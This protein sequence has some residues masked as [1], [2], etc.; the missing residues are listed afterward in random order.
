MVLVEN[1]HG[2]YALI[3]FKAHSVPYFCHLCFKNF[4]VH[5]HNKKKKLLLNIQ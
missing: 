3:D 2:F 5:I 1:S 4:Q